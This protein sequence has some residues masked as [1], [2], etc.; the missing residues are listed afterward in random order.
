[1]FCVSSN[2][3]LFLIKEGV[4]NAPTVQGLSQKQQIAIIKSFKEGKLNTLIATCV[5]EE[6]LDIGDVDL[7]VCY[8]SGFSPIRTIQRKGK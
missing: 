1:M 4:L 3:K 5:G 6:G 7:I 8:D 2:F